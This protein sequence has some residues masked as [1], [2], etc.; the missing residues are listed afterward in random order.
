MGFFRLG[1][2]RSVAERTLAEAQVERDRLRGERDELLA[3]LQR[4]QRRSQEAETRARDAEERAT[5]AE[6]RAKAAEDHAAIAQDRARAAEARADQLATRL[7]AE[8]SSSSV[9]ATAPTP[10]GSLA[11]GADAAVMACWP[12]VLGHLER[13]WA[14]GLGATPGSRGI[15]AGTVASQITES[16]ARE[17]DRLRE[18]VGV[19]VSFTVGD[20]VDPANPVVFLLSA[21]DLMGA[22]AS[23]CERM[24]VDLDGQLVLGGEVWTDLGDEIE[25]SRA[26]AQTA[27]AMVDPIDVG[28]ER[29]TVTLRA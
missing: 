6:D 14:T 2:G 11:G 1:K 21:T 12:L 26:R 22:M 25:S 19:D 9:A 7:S 10:T 4:E 27:G 15:P 13:R 24:V 23:R 8:T 3:A 17:V 16:L 18:E 5:S 28:N 29:V 20:V